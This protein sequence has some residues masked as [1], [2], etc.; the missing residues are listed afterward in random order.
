MLVAAATTL[1]EPTPP[2]PSQAHHQSSKTHSPFRTVNTA[3][4]ATSAW[5]QD[6]HS[7]PVRPS[8]AASVPALAPA[9]MPLAD[10]W[11]PDSGYA[12][13]GTMSAA[14]G[15]CV[16][17]A[18]PGRLCLGR[19]VGRATSLHGCRMCLEYLPSTSILRH[20]FKNKTINSKKN[21][22]VHK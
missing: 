16:L 2:G 21:R 3:L 6:K 22:Y 4:I 18:V 12:G 5:T 9:E 15:G 10:R 1:G 17:Q 14:R 7:L 11:P 20:T 19:T 8:P 13:R